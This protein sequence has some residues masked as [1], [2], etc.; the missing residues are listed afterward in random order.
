MTS[1]HNNP[2]RIRE[3]LIRIII[4]IEHTSPH[5][6]PKIIRPQPQQKFEH[7]GV[8]VVV[9]ARAVFPGGVIIAVISVS[10]KLSN[11]NSRQGG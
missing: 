4:H 9:E 11:L 8:E 6:R 7:V 2:I 1:T 5:S 10:P 3:R